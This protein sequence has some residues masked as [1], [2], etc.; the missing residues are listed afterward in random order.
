MRMQ[1]VLCAL[2]AIGSFLLILPPVAVAQC[3][4]A[5]LT[6]SD[7][8]KGDLFGGTVAVSG[9]YVVVGAHGD[10]D[11]CPTDPS[12]NSGA[13]YVFQRQGATWLQHAK[14]V[15][16]D[17]QLSARFGTSASMTSDVLV[18]GASGASDG[19]VDSGAAYV[20]R[21]DGTNWI[22]EAKLVPSDGGD[23]DSFGSAVSIS[24]N[25][26]V[27]GARGHDGP[28]TGT[29]AAYVF[30]Y[31]GAAWVE[32]QKLTASDLAELDIFGG[33]ASI[34]GDTVIVA[35]LGQDAGYVF[36]R[37]GTTWTQ[38]AKL[39]PADLTLG[40]EIGGVSIV[41]D[42]A[43]IGYI[44]PIPPP[45]SV[46]GNAE[47]VLQENGAASSGSV[48]VFRRQA[49]EWVESEKLVPGDAGLHALFGSSVAH[50]L[51]YI[52]VGAADDDPAGFGS[53]SAYIFQRVGGAFFRHSK[54][55]AS[56][57]APADGFG[58]SAAIDGSH[59]VIGAPGNDDACPDEFVCDSG[60]AYVFSLAEC[61]PEIPT[62]SQWGLLVLGV[63]LAAGGA[64]VVARR[65]RGTPRGESLQS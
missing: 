35:A 10:D 53:G 55:I 11:A 19:V 26:I 31:D 9:D 30:S 39:R 27:V 45:A 41:N 24:G 7:A 13:A 8:A 43:V 4:Q 1:T 58:S 6:A 46:P 52:A 2:A 37:S 33:R 63:L 28:G 18:V 47:A 12:C 56:D 60:S 3:E 36:R 14:L 34:S 23:G 65:E 57:A 61:R 22:Q 20:F 5:K 51:D 40:D 15:A 48:F 62:V 16:S 64:V 59:I 50:N 42:L 32:Q 17:P 21:H 25:D 54:L 29:G 49:G 38:E 44:Q